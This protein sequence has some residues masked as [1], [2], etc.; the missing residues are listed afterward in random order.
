MWEQVIGEWVKVGSTKGPCVCVC[1]CTWGWGWGWGWGACVR[2][3]VLLIFGLMPYVR[4][5]CIPSDIW[6]CVREVMNS[7]CNQEHCVQAILSQIAWFMGPT[8]G[9]P[10]S[11][12]PQMGPMNLAVRDP[13][14]LHGFI[15]QHDINLVSIKSAEK[16][17]RLIFWQRN[18]Q[19]FME[20]SSG[21]KQEHW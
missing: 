1:V 15:Y 20:F 8:W 6:A 9:P 13:I 18:L 4:G 14:L 11:Y 19:V 16:N 10:G 7:R 3:C 17:N 12:R 2:V 5:G 21:W